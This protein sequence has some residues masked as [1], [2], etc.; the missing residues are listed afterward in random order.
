MA[1]DFRTCGKHCLLTFSL[2]KSSHKTGFS[3]SKFVIDMIDCLV[4]GPHVL[5]FRD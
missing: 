1:L 4:I 5:Q 2:P 3:V